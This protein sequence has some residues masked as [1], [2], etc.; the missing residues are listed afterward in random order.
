MF[1]GYR[2]LIVSIFSLL[3]LSCSSYRQLG[4][5]VASKGK[6]CSPRSEPN[7]DS[8]FIPRK[9]IGPVVSGALSAKFSERIILI[10]NACGA[11]TDL[12]ELFDLEMKAS[13]SEDYSLVIAQKKQEISQRVSLAL[14]E[15]AS[16]ES[17][18]N[19]ERDRCQQA[20]NYLSEIEGEKVR[21][22]TV[23]SIIFG[24]LTTVGT[25][26]VSTDQQVR[27]VAFLGGILT[28]GLGLRTLFIKR[29]IEFGH[30][31]NILTD[32][33]N[34][35]ETSKTYPASI[36]YVLNKR[37]F[38]DSKE[39]SVNHYIRLRW[40][41]QL[42]TYKES[43]RL[44]VEK[45]LFGSGANYGI[46]E[47]RIRESMLSLIQVGVSLTNHDLKLLLLEMVK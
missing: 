46:N 40:K 11:L 41:A 30:E 43:K 35:S 7:Y 39:F 18:I 38:T 29:E 36:W 10:A 31:R 34:E 44:A 12:Q 5:E 6:Y 4:I 45:L 25:T 27:S 19:C 47:L 1:P 14:S 42:D 33:W 28:A 8:S 20:I 17:E 21:R 24:A 22:S 16:L 23:A 15:V 9:N 37:E 2:S 13:D 32:I 26:L 3:G